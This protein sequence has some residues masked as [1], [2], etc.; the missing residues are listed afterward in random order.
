MYPKTAQTKGWVSDDFN[1]K[2]TPATFKLLFLATE[3]GQ[4]SNPL[5]NEKNYRKNTDQHFAHEDSSLEI[6]MGSLDAA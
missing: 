6:L 1:K 5:P 4:N 2:R 3:H